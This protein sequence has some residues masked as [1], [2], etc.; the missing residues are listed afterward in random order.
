[1]SYDR[2]LL[3]NIVETFAVT[4]GVPAFLLDAEGNISSPSRGFLPQEWTFADI[5][6]LKGAVCSEARLGALSSDRY[7]TQVTENQFIYLFCPVDTGA[8]HAVLVAGPA[9]FRPP[10]EL[11]LTSLLKT[12]QISLKKKAEIAAQIARLP[13]VSMVRLDH[14]GRVLWSLAQAYTT[15]GTSVLP[16]L[17]GHDAVRASQ[18]NALPKV[19][20]TLVEEDVHVSFKILSLART[21]LLSGDVAGIRAMRDQYLELPLDKL[22][23]KD[24][25]RS[26]RDN[27]ISAC[28]A[29]GGLLIFE[30]NAPYEQV[31]M[32]HDQYI[33]LGEQTNSIP[34]LVDLIFQALEAFT[35]MM[36]KYSTE[37]YTKPVRQVV[38]Y[39]QA[40][41]TRKIAL[42]DLATLTGLS[43]SYLSRRIKK[44]TGSS[45]V[46]LIDSY[47]IEES[48]YLLLNTDESIHQ[49]AE[50]TGF[51]YQYHFSLRF[52]KYTGMTPTRFR[53]TARTST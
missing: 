19:N 29:F 49:I 48:K 36:R 52:K 9:R 23:Q 6:S 45:L 27:L 42:D 16:D 26:V 35:W 8:S 2:S 38:Q 24:D 47:R 11:Q 18:D 51:H 40:D 13:E 5:E 50:Q 17:C 53:Q 31:M 1:M 30:H 34:E 46:D 39:I 4:T 12:N 37:R 21:F 33:R 28:G 32:A 44:E 20:F 3:D 43:K 10:S 41:I 14:L 7:Y 25:L 15:K 22:I